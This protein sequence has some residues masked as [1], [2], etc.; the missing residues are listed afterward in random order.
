MS[1]AQSGET[2]RIHYTGTLTDGT[3]FDSSAGR[4]PLEFVLGSGQVIP[5]FDKAVTGMS[6]GDSK[7]V[8]IEAGDAYG[9]R[10]A[11]LVQQVARSVI[12]AELE[13]EVG[14]QLQGQSESG[15]VQ[16]FVITEVSEENITLDGN[17]PLA[18]QALT[19]AIELVGIGAN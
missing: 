19:F 14:M 16:H 13:P 18:G 12:P 9:D 15:E 3:Q 1:Q 4:D 6:V 8:T 7:T 11:E 10:H 2:V 17:H 5:G